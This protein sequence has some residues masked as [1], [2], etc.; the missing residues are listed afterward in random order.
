MTEN[1]SMKVVY[2]QAQ[3]RERDI[4]PFLRAIDPNCPIPQSLEGGNGNGGVWQ[5]MMDIDKKDELLICTNFRIASTFLYTTD[6]QDELY[7][8][9]C[10]VQWRFGEAPI[11]SRVASE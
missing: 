6:V 8:P 10:Y 7:R 4:T 3:T 2:F 1:Y 9:D 11:L 5:C